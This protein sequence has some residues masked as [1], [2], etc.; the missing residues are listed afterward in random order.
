MILERCITSELIDTL[1]NVNED[2]KELREQLG[3]ELID[4]LW[5]VN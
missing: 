1:W 5:N 4:T 2:I 3:R